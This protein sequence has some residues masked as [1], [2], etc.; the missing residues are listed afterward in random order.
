MYG[1]HSARMR[2]EIDVP[3]GTIGLAIRSPV[4][5][6]S[7]AV[8]LAHWC[9]EDLLTHF[10]DEFRTNNRIAFKIPLPQLHVNEMIHWEYIDDVGALVIVPKGTADEAVGKVRELGAKVRG[11]FKAQGFGFHKDTYGTTAISLGHELEPQ[12]FGVW[13]SRKAIWGAVG[14][15]EELLR[16]KQAAAET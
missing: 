15:T 7:W 1:M 3:D 13:A 16:V 5:G 2:V 10:V 4:M 9:L 14:A 11:E 12:G 8:I 6:W